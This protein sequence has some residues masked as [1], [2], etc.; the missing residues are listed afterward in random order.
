MKYIIRAVISYLDSNGNKQL[1]EARW[2]DIEWGAAL[3]LLRIEVENL[4]DSDG[5]IVTNAQAYKVN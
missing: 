2:A 5:A 1:W 4:T 3:N